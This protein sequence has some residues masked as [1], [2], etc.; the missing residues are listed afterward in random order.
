MPCSMPSLSLLGHAPADTLARLA[1]GAEPLP[2]TADAV[3]LGGGIMGCAAAWYLA[4][5]GQS[6][7][8][9]DVAR[10]GSQQSGRNWGFVRSLCRDPAELPLAALALSLWPGLQADLGHETGWRQRGCLFV[11][12]DDAEQASHADWLKEAGDRVRD[13]RLLSA[14]EVT[15]AFP[16]LGSRTAGGILAAGDG[17]AEPLL[18][19]LAFARAACAAGAVLIED[20][21]ARAIETSAGRISGVVTEHGRIATSTVICTAGARSHRLLAGLI[22][23]LPQ[24]TVRSTVALT[25]PMADLD[26]PCFV[27]AGLGLRQR[28]DGSCI[29]A[30]D[31]GT[32]VDLTLDSFRAAGFFL[33]ELIQRRRAFSL[34]LGRP[35]ADD[36]IER[37]AE[38]ATTRT[39]RPRAP[40]I[41]ANPKRVSDA[42][43]RFAT[44]F[45]AAGTPPIAKSWAGAIDV[46]PDA[47]P[48]I[49]AP[50]ATP[51]L[52]VATGFSGHGFGLG[53]GV[54]RVLA[55]LALGRPAPVDI[56]PFAADRFATGRW[57]RPYGGI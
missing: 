35:F 7:V 1:G 47:L 48:V 11:A 31:G 41:P 38:P 28:P 26:L 3:I 39:L 40:D 10:I 2:A 16:S 57:R 45:P 51:G 17:Q 18:A 8:L 20:C 6:V 25:A 32:D 21:G 29:I 27:G 37:L 56:T 50:A 24:K 14:A 52:L 44:L 36:L 12:A 22:P 34:K 55:D 49:D 15:R 13:T 30:T 43:R 33:R 23:A 53:P 19:T 4:R 54:G 9:I 42:A 5:A 46:M